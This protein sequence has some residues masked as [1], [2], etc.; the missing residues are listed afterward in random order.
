MAAVGTDFCFSLHYGSFKE[1]GRFDT[2]GQF[3]DSNIPLRYTFWCAKNFYSKTAETTS[4]SRT[5][6]E[7]IDLEKPGLYLNL[8]K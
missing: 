6:L 7:S 8:E 4:I 3:G 2:S 5:E 1:N